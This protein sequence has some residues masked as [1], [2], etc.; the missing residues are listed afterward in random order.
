MKQNHSVAL[1]SLIL[2]TSGGALELGSKVWEK[3]SDMTTEF[4]QNAVENLEAY[5]VVFGV[6]SLA[7]GISALTT[8]QEVSFDKQMDFH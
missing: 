7:A 4:N 3:T 5:A 8:K 6:L 2:L 1:T